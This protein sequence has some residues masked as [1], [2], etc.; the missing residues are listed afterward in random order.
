[1]CKNLKREGVG[2]GV[3]L[4]LGGGLIMGSEIDMNE[5]VKRV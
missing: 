2:A 1:M 4:G 5:N 3:G